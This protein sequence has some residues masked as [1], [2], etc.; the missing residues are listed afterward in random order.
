MK[1]SQSSNKDLRKSWTLETGNPN[2]LLKRR[3]TQ[4]P[5]RSRWPY[6]MWK[7]MN[8][9]MLSFLLRGILHRR[10]PPQLTNFIQKE[11]QLNQVWALHLL[12]EIPSSQTQG[13]LDICRNHNQSTTILIRLVKKTRIRHQ[14]HRESARARSK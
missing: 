5:I 11:Y 13:F 12:Q 6:I 10:S 3:H 7:N 9:V 4:W 14:W 2:H 8:R 1:E